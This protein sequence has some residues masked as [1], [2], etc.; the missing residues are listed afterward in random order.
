LSR[1]LD[2]SVYIFFD[3]PRTAM[4]SG[5]LIINFFMGDVTGLQT[6]AAARELPSTNT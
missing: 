4:V 3:S 1:D 2:F 6:A 5:S